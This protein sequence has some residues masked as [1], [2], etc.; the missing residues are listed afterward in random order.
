MTKMRDV[1]DGA[2]VAVAGGGMAIA[3]VVVTAAHDYVVA[4]EAQ[5]SGKG[6]SRHEQF[7]QLPL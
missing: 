2:G 6:A 3:A 4:V 1:D 7:S 5:Q